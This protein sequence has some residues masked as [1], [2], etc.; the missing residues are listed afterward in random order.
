MNSKQEKEAPLAPLSSP[1]NLQFWTYLVILTFFLINGLVLAASVLIPLTISLFAVVLIMAIVDRLS[2]LIPIWLSHIV[3]LSTVLITILSVLGILSQQAEAVVAAFPRY[4]A[5][6]ADILSHLVVFI[7]D[8][9]YQLILSGIND[10]QLF[11][12]AQRAVASTGK[13]LSGIFLVLIYVPFMLKEWTP[14][15]GKLV[16]AAPDTETQ[17]KV[18]TILES[19]S[20]SLQR[21]VGVKTLVSMVTGG[22]SYIIFKII[23]LDFAEAWAFIVFALNFIPNIGSILGVAFPSLLALLQFDTSTPFLIILFGCGIIQFTIG[24][25]IEPAITGRSLN[26]S[27][28]IVILALTF[29]TSIWGIAGAL[30]S[31]PI[32]AC[33]LIIMAHIPATRSI[34]ILISG[35]GNLTTIVRRKASISTAEESE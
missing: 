12:F 34:A 8:D 27:P 19:M 25:V 4:E 28:F 17:E 26:L 29:W 13:L 6:F 5:R 14:M 20:E 23:G 9:N 35:D 22:A 33:T 7:G 3:A 24:N 18:R 11:D 15:R 32:T 16:L 30:M 21:Y 31:V 10:L 1:F 2:K